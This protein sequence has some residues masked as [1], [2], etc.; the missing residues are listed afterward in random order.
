M[1]KIHSDYSDIDRHLDKVGSAPTTTGKAALETVLGMA[2]IEL[3]RATHV[4]TGSL[5]A[6]EKA[7]SDSGG[8]TWVGTLTAGGPSTGV[9][10][11]VDYAIYER[12]R[13]DAHDFLETQDLLAPAWIAAMMK[14]WD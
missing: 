9:N 12:A 6:S 8:N 7:E 14:G 2:L 4:Q 10:N 5:V 3:K 13:G 1:I 11:P